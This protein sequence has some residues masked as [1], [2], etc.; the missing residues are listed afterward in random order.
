M[1]TET[2]K[3]TFILKVKSPSLQDYL[4]KKIQKQF[5]FKNNFFRWFS[6]FSISPIYI[7]E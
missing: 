2:N 1:N 5:Q 7:A 6:M 4:R 3:N